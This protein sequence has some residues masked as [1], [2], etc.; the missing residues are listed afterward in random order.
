MYSFLS[1]TKS[2]HSI[3][4]LLLL[5]Q[6]D[7]HHYFECWTR[8][9]YQGHV[10]EGLYLT[11]FSV[12]FVIFITKSRKSIKSKILSNTFKD[13]GCGILGFFVSFVLFQLFLLLAAQKK[14]FG[15]CWGSVVVASLVY[16]W[17]LGVFFSSLFS[18]FVLCCF[19]LFSKKNTQLPLPGFVQKS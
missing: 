8:M 18:F 5:V 19:R 15:V 9:G 10:V 2:F 13:F 16:S 6:I 7:N 17:S 3:L 12:S 11:S 4:S 1:H 14:Y